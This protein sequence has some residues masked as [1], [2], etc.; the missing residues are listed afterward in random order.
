MRATS[1]L[2]AEPT[3]DGGDD[4]TLSDETT[5][6]VLKGVVIGIAI[7]VIIGVFAGRRSG[8]CKATTS[9]RRR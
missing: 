7:A 1:G 3:V 4:Q 2:D 8:R 5:N 6:K 9:H